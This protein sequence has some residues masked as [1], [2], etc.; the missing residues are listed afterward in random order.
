ME[1]LQH[2]RTLFEY[3]NWANQEV[4][5][6]VKAADEPP[7]RSVKLLA[8]VIAAEFVWFDRL[9]QQPQSTPVWP[10]LNLQ[11]CAARLQSLNISWRE[12]L[13]GLSAE[14]LSQPIHYKNSKGEAWDSTVG[15]ILT[16]V[17]MHSAYHRG[18]IALDIRSSGYVPALTDYIHWA[19]QK[20]ALS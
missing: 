5:K 6:A 4:L 15:E 3:D 16:H 13:N 8:H 18:Q 14:G 12:Y 10:E 19:R 9:K 2:V 7:Q 17:A 1:M 20:F 11:E